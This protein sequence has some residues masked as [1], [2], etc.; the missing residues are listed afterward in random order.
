[1]VILQISKLKFREVKQLA[2]GQTANKWKIWDS[3]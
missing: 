2:L 1:M 3:E